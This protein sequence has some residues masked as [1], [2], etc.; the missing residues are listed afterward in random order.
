MSEPF[1]LPTLIDP[2]SDRASDV[3][4]AQSSATGSDP[5]TPI[6]IDACDGGD[7]GPCYPTDQNEPGRLPGEPDTV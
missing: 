6:E 4:A 2:A 7:S 1:T 5:R 3:V